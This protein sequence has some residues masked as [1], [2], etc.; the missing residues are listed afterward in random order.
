MSWVVGTALVLLV[1]VAMPLK[2]LA[3]E[4]V[5]VEVLGPIHGFLYLGYLLTIIDLARHVRVR[6]LQVVAMVAAGLI[7][8]MTFVVERRMV[9]SLAAPVL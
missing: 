6:A 7:P 5:G 8:F 4:P 1:L 2:Y 3:D 9:R